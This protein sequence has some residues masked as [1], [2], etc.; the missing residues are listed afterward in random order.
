MS[1][2]TFSQTR[3][4]ALNL[5]KQT[6]LLLSQYSRFQA[7]V[8]PEAGPDE[9][10]VLAGIKQLLEKRDDTIT[11]LNRITEAQDINAVSTSKLQQ[12]TRHKEILNDHRKSYLKMEAA[13]QDERNKNNL[14]FSV[15]SDITA[16][17][18]R[19]E[20]GASLN[21]NDYILDE[22][23]R[24]D[25][26]NSFAD[27]LLQQAYHTR[28]ELY[29]QRQYLA[30]A[31]L[32]MLGAVQAVPGINVLISKINTRRKRDTLILATVISVCILL[33]FFL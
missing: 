12:L 31:Q 6:E 24:V 17:K 20:Q 19:T 14:L 8:T 11:K 25:S 2:A 32:R 21:A 4:Q 22:R 7:A 28:D 33:L 26:A 15:R 10:R 3:S 9:L 23:V 16:H 27:R 5:E 13:I 30:G 29:S 18:K 1:S